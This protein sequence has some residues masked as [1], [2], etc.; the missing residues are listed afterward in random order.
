MQTP[1]TKN[2]NQGR[3]TM[4]NFLGMRCPKCGDEDRLDIQATV[5]IRVCEDG[6][7]ADASRDGTHDYEPGSIA[8]CDACGCCDTVREFELA[9]GAS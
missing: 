9:G 5:W 8:R 7:D 3:N 4:S 1:T 2:N 6:T